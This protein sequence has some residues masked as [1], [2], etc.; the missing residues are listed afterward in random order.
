MFETAREARNAAQDK[1]REARKALP[2]LERTDRAAQAAL[3]QYETDIARESAE[4]RS[5]ED[6]LERLAREIKESTAQRDTAIKA[7]ESLQGGE[8][9]TAQQEELSEKLA[10]ARAHACLL[11]TSPSPRDRG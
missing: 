11:Y 8:D 2:D 9:V 3:A 4:K 10:A 7:N 5:L 1:A 6:R